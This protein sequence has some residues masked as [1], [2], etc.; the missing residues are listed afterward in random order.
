MVTRRLGTRP[1]GRTGR[2]PV[3]LFPTEHHPDQPR[4]GWLLQCPGGPTARGSG[5]TSSHTALVLS[6]GKAIEDQ[7]SLV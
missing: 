6:Q 7:N 4:E 3:L 2:H 1:R 5:F